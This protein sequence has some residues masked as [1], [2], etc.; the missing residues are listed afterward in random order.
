MP[1]HSPFTLSNHT[2]AASTLYPR[3]QHEGIYPQSGISSVSRSRPFAGPRVGTVDLCISQGIN[4][5]APNPGRVEAF[6]NIH[7]P[8][9]A[10]SSIHTQQSRGRNQ[11]HH[12]RAHRQ[13]VCMCITFIYQRASGHP[14]RSFSQSALDT[15]L[16]CCAWACSWASVCHGL[17][18]TNA[19]RMPRG[20]STQ[21]QGHLE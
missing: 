10:A 8:S 21:T 1:A 6:L 17:A 12:P 4:L 5:A 13:T 3:K 9:Y 15:G 14:Y 7:A 11:H 18:T 20:S 19:C 16:F 2:W